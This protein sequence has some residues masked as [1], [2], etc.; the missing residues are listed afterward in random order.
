MIGAGKVIVFY[1]RHYLGVE[2]IIVMYYIVNYFGIADF[3][4]GMFKNY[5]VNYFQLN[6]GFALME[7]NVLNYF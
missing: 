5:V 3:F 4:E 2:K 6:G 7:K 1:V